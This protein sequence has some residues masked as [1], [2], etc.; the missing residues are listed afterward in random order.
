MLP[1][2]LTGSNEETGL[3]VNEDNTV[4]T[5]AGTVIPQ[6]PGTAIVSGIVDASADSVGG[7]VDIFGTVIGLVDQAQINV[8]GDTGGGEIRVGGEYKGRVQFQPLT[9]R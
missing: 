6:Q 2:L 5:T 4:Q 3:T 7:N 9:P 8:S 1:E